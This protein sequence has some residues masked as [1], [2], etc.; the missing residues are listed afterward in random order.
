MTDALG[1]DPRATMAVLG[2]GRVM[3]LATEAVAVGARG[4]A[5]GGR[6]PS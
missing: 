4:R 5:A 3:D 2:Y 1:A 6:P